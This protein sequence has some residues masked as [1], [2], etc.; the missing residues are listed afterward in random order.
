MHVL[1]SAVE[2]GIGYAIM[3]LNLAM[4][5]VEEGRLVAHRISAEGLSRNLGICSSASMPA[6]HLK[7]LICEL[8]REVVWIMCESDKWS[9]GRVL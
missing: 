3:P 7:T 2:A 4:R 1:K 9:G 5:E 8:I 6:S